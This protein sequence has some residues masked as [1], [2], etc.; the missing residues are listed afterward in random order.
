LTSEDE[1]TRNIQ[2]DTENIGKSKC[3]YSSVSGI[4][5]GDAYA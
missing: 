1:L 4:G 2:A 3:T 5:R